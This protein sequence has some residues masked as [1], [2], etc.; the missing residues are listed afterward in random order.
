MVFE[1]EKYVFDENVKEKVT[2]RKTVIEVGGSSCDGYEN[3]VS[4]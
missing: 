3:D 2:Y 1:R 4:S